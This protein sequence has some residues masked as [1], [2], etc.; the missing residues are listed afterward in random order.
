MRLDPLELIMA[1]TGVAIA[2]TRAE[3]VAQLQSTIVA[4]RDLR[5]DS[6]F[7]W[8]GLTLDGRLETGLATSPAVEV[9]D[10]YIHRLAEMRERDAGAARTLDGPHRSDLLVR[11]GP[12]DMA[13]ARCSTGEQKALMVGIVLAHAELMAQRRG[14]AVPIL[15]FDEIAAHLDQHRRAALFDEICR[16][17]AQCWM[18][19]TDDQAFS[20]LAGRALFLHVGEAKVTPRP[21]VRQ[22]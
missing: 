15:L 18:T 7:P 12:K 9:E 20:A 21:P 14:G 3:V 11:H 4:R 22:G 16:L 5:P 10:Q 17:G 8:A 2:A 1:E 6:P 13:A 19:G